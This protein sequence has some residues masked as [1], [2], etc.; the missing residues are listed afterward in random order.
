MEAPSWFW[1]GQFKNEEKFAKKL[2]GKIAKA[3]K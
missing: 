2:A 3:A 1:I